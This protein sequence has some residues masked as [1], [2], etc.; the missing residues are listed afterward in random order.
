MECME[1]EVGE[2][3]KI[4][5]D[6]KSMEMTGADK[7]SFAASTHC[8]ICGD[9]LSGDKVRDHD[10]LT[11]RYRGAAH[12]QCNLD[13]QLPKYVPIVF[14]NLSG[15]DTYLFVKELGFGEGKIDCIPH[16]D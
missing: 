14:H 10:H 13:F 11:G 16:T 12:N 6:N 3:A 5:G 1:K 2:I 7:E 4:Y 8:H 15:Y 9:A